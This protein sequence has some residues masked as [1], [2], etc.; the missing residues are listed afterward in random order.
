MT[1]D[2]IDTRNEFGKMRLFDVVEGDQER[3]ETLDLTIVVDNS[4]VE[5]HANGRFALST[6]VR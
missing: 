6:W 1:T 3:I 4:I 5:V 2:G